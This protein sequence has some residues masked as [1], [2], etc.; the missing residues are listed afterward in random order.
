MIKRINWLSMITSPYNYVTIC[1]ELLIT[2][3]SIGMETNPSYHAIGRLAPC[4]S[5][6]NS[7]T[8]KCIFYIFYTYEYIF[9]L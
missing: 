9:N 2:D 8:E 1:Y 3:I 4:R 6:L 7:Y 5:I